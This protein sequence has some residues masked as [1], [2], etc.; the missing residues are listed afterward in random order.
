VRLLDC[1]YLSRWSQ[2]ESSVRT[3][4]GGDDDDDDERLK[5]SK[6]RTEETRGLDVEGL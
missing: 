4:G 5:K 2:L 1:W 3:A 6:P